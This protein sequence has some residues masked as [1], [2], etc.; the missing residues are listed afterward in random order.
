[1][2]LKGIIQ[3]SSLANKMEMEAKLDEMMQPNPEQ[4]AMQQA[5]FQLA[6]ATAQANLQ[7]LES[8]TAK[9][10]S[11]AQKT[12]T[13]TQLMPVEVQAKLAQ[14]LSANIRGDNTQNE[15]AQRAKIAELALKEAD[16]N[17]NERIA[18]AQMSRKMQ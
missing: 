6:T 18:I 9:N 1:M 11:Q 2:I 15:F 5:E 17:S 7:K 16:I 13:E 10:M 14:G 3:S 8:E 12:A 4:Q